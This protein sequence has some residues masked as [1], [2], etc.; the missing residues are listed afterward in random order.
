M[1]EKIYGIAN[2]A[3]IIIMLLELFVIDARPKKILFDLF[4]I[5]Y[6]LK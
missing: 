3:E 2:I 5:I 4:S 1:R 6:D